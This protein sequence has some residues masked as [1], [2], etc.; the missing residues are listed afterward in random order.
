MRKSNVTWRYKAHNDPYINIL[1]VLAFIMK[2]NDIYIYD[3]IMVFQYTII[4]Y[5]T[6][7]VRFGCVG[8][9]GISKTCNFHKNIVAKYVVWGALTSRQP[10]LR[11]S[12]FPA[13]FLLKQICQFPQLATGSTNIDKEECFP[14]LLEKMMNN[15]HIYPAHSLR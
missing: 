3:Y 5:T 8:N 2:N 12:S 4:G 1:K 7:N 15:F 13:Q 10:I 6:S 11:F 9:W 14:D